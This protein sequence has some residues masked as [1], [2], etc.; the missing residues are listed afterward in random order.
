MRVVVSLILACLF[1]L[2]AGFNVWNM[3]TNRGTST[4]SV[5][6]WTQVH[7]G[8]GY[9]FIALY[10]ILCYFMLLRIKGSADEL[11]PQLVLHM[12]LALSLA[13]LLVVKVIVARY[14]K[15]ARG[16]LMA[17]GIG[18]F[19]IAFTLVALNFSIHFL[20]VASTHKE[21]IGISA[22]FIAL[23]LILAVIPLVAKAGLPMPKSK[24]AVPSLNK[25]AG[26]ELSN[27][28]EAFNLTLARIESQ[29]QD[30]KTL[31]FLLPGYSLILDMLISPSDRLYR[32]YIKAGN[33]WLCFPVSK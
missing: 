21:P 11:S 2:L 5:R 31:R 19:A 22:T 9:A 28:D 12:G 16:L 4:R 30:A 15:A 14:Q 3:L 25:S 24:E 7:R 20:Q 33:Q 1:V 10:V 26:Q 29:T 6:L 13:P 27:R 32:D 18:I 17:L 8:A 23:A